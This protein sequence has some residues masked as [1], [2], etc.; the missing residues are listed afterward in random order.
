MWSKA[1]HFVDR[2]PVGTADRYPV[3]QVHGH[4]VAAI[5]Q[6]SGSQT[7]DVPTADSRTGAPGWN[8]YI[9]V[10]DVDRTVTAAALAGGHLVTEAVDI[11]DAGRM[12]VMADPVEQPSGSGRRASTTERPGQRTEHVELE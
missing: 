4:A 8:T 5:A 12:A 7:A 2:T 1:D 11:G 3:A 6:T 9:A 10:D